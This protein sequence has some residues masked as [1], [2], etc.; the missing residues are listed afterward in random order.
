M[1]KLK[2]NPIVG[3]IGFCGR[4]VEVLEGNRGIQERGLLLAESSR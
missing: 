1:K 4:F 2:N 3:D